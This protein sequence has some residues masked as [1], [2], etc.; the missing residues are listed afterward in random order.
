VE[1]AEEFD[2]EGAGEIGESVVRV[3]R[4]Y[5]EAQEAR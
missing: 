3:I 4:C 2:A 1:G 5:P